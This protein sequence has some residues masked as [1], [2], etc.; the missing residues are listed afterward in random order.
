MCKKIATANMVE[1]VTTGL[2]AGVCK[3]AYFNVFHLSPVVQLQ[4][5]MEVNQ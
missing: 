1:I 4:E 2:L 3:Q 5:Q